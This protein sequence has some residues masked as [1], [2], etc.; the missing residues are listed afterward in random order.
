M[1]SFLGA[2]IMIALMMFVFLKNIRITIFGIITNLIPVFA[3]ALIMVLF[4]IPLDMGTVMIA[5]IM[6]GIAVDD[7]MHFLHAYLH[8]HEN[9]AGKGNIV[10]KALVLTSPALLAS[11]IALA[12]G[13]LILGMSSVKSLHNFGILCAAVVIIAFAADVLFLSSILKF[14]MN[15]KS[16]K[17]LSQ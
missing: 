11:S 9:N 16:K 6:L 8:N 12:A 13:F 4:R 2:F 14:S 15:K 17:Y 3:V 7:T 1:Y 10:D 5:A